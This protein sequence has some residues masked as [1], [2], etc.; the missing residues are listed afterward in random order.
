MPICLQ[1]VLWKTPPLPPITVQH[2]AYVGLG[3]RH[4]TIANT[5]EPKSLCHRTCQ[6][7]D[8]CKI[9]F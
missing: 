2:G 5:E 9:T 8:L 4:A 6:E 3:T 1:D 7:M